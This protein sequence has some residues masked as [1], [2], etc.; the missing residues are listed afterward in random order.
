MILREMIASLYGAWRLARLDAGGLR[1]FDASPRGAKRSFFAAV[2]V[3]PIFVLATGLLPPPGTAEGG[4]RWIAAEG[5]AYVVSW[6]AYPVVV[7]WLTR[8]FGCRE[9]FEGWLSA[10]NWSMVLQNAALLPLAVLTALDVLPADAMQLVWLAAFALIMGWLWFI[11]RSAL[12][13]SP[14]TALG[15][16]ILDELLSA[17][18][19]MLASHLS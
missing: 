14:M 3:A 6:V 5:I 12:A 1:L 16:V 18:I 11:A 9:R 13:V 19:D 8:K 17:M 10:Y 4:F 2:V 15:L 7:E